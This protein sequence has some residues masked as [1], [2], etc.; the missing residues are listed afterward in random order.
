M[1]A[2]MFGGSDVSSVS[3]LM[4]TSRSAARP[5]SVSAVRPPVVRRSLAGR[6]GGEARA[7]RVVGLDVTASVCGFVVRGLSRAASRPRF[8]S[9][10]A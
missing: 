6:V 2:V 1:T 7:L 8:S 9:R 10:D 3:T 4:P 5:I